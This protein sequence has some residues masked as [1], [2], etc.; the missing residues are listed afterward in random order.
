MHVGPPLPKSRVRGTT[1]HS[2]QRKEDDWVNP[3][4]VMG[5]Q[6]WG[7][8]QMNKQMTPKF[9]YKCLWEHFCCN[10]AFGP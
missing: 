6:S 5:R 7:K 10:S 1:L 4:L 2:M 3:L 9:T 8:K